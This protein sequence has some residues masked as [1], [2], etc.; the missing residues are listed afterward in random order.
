MA[1]TR[2]LPAEDTYIHGHQGQTYEEVAKALNVFFHDDGENPRTAKSVKDRVYLLKKSPPGQPQE[3]LKT[4]WGDDGSTVVVSNRAFTVEEMAEMFGLDMDLWFAKKLITN[5]WGMHTQ[6]KVFW[7]AVEV[8][9][10]AKNWDALLAELEARPRTRTPR[11]QFL[12]AVG[13]RPLYEMCLFDAH[14]GSK[15]WGPETGEDYDLDIAIARYKDAFTDL[16]GRAP[17]GA[18][19]CWVVGNDLFHFDTLIQGKGGA[20]AKGTPQDVDSRWQKLFIAVCAMLEEC[21]H[22]ALD[23]DCVGLDIVVVGGNHDTQTTFYAGQWLAAAL[24]G[25]DVRVD[26]SPK[27]RKYYR[28]HDVLLG[29]THGNEEKQKDLYGLMAEEA[30]DV[31]SQ[32]NFREWHLG[33]FHQEECSEDGTMRIRT[34]TALSA[35]ESW[36]KSKGYRSLPGARAFVW[37]P[38]SGIARQ[39]YYNVPLEEATTDPTVMLES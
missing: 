18:R 14:I 25:P 26:N 30:K 2:W 12:P 7:E 6:T 36:H 15:A 37:E 38:G 33:H 1:Y 4:E 16:L 9:H 3:K 29:Y 27:Q 13:I 35:T 39:E 32:V 5:V 24:R 10:L 21:A 28:Y 19:I 31:W 8:E 23:T 34:I 22:A 11:Y 20:T 17:R